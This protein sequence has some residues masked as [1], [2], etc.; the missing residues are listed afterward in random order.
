METL[1]MRLDLIIYSYNSYSFDYNKTG[2]LIFLIGKKE[3]R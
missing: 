1:F 3:M 2:M